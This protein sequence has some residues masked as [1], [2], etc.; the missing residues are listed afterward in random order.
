MQL[1][2]VSL[3]LLIVVVAIVS[4]VFIVGMRRNVSFDL[5]SVRL[6]AFGVHDAV[7]LRTVI[8]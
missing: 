5:H 6:A 7:V 1:V 4:V 2:I 3:I 8:G